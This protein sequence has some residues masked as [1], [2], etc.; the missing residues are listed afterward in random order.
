[1]NLFTAQGLS[2]TF[3][4]RPLFTNL[5]I[6]MSQGQKIALIGLNGCG[7]STLL[8]IIAGFETAELGIVSKRKELKVSYLGQDPVFDPKMTAFD[9]VFHTRGELMDA[10][11][12][13]ED[14]ILLHHDEPGTEDRLNAAISNMD[15]LGGWNYEA[16]INQILSKLGINN[17][18]QTLGTMSGGQVKRVALAAVLIEDADLLIMDE[19]T[20]HLDTDMI[21]WMEGFLSARATSLLM[22]THDRYFLNQVCNLILELDEG[23]LFSYKGDYSYFLEKKSE[24]EEADQA[25]LEK[26]RNT[27]RKELDWIRRMPKARSTKSK[28]RIDAFYDLK[29]KT[30]NKK[31]DEKLEL[32]VK[33]TRIGG[34]ILEM[35]HVYKSFG[36]NEVIKNFSYTFKKRERIGIVGANGSGKSTFLNIITGK[37]EATSGK[38]NPGDNTVYGYYSQ[39]GIHSTE[40]IR[41]I[42][43]V[44]KYAEV[45]V[46]A[47]GTKVNVSQ[48]LRHFLFSPEKQ[49]TYVSRL[50]GGE[51]RRLH[52]LTVLIANPNFLILDE[53]TNDL[54]LIT[55]SILEDFL[56]SYP[57]CLVIVSHD[58]YFM[59]R[60]TDHMFIFEG[61]GVITDF[62]GNYSDYR[63]WL[64]DKL[65]AEKIESKIENVKTTQVKIEEPK[66]VE[67]KKLS[68]KEQKEYESLEAEI[69]KLEEKKSDLILKLNSGEGNHEELKKWA[70]N[71]SY[72]ISEIDKKT[73]RWIELLEMVG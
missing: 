49:H 61:N 17:L 47:D 56:L 2:K 46:L 68:Y 42:D 15:T 41:V 60:L 52:L 62:N 10:I 22:V 13:Y 20:N 54:D 25:T 11:R 72:T 55:L 57:G 35:K 28:S 63:D 27:L 6:S 3:A 16:E 69:A 18:E 73:L 45:I 70:D 48:F 65:D 66:S 29:G 59:D 23:K 38:I 71:I 21:E 58:R 34:K 9:H 50:S 12:E 37:E 53:P 14:C 39:Q 40:E 32:D 19:P 64:K 51:K 8:K 33:I 36:D 26:N 24:R 44:K 30:V 1:M 43:F 7:K 67:K 4:D 31:P 5:D